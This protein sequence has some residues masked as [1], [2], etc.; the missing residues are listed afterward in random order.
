M[1]SPLKHRGVIV[2]MST[3]FTPGGDVDDDAAER[4][5]DRLAA[6]G[7]SVFVLGTTGE[8]SS[9]PTSQRERVVNSALRAAAKRV[10]VYAGIGDNSLSD[11][12]SAG[13]RYLKLGAAAVVAHM[14]SYYPIQPEEMRSYFERLHE[15]VHGPLMLYNI[16]QTT[17]MSLPL[18]VVEQL[19]SLPRVVGF[20]DS[21]N[22]PGRLEEVARRFGGRPRFSI[23]MG[24]ASQS[25]TAMRAG[26]DGVI[27]SS[28]NLVPE[29]WERFWNHASAGEWAQAEELQ[30][31]LD[32][33]GQVLQ[34]SRG[35]GGYLAALK[36]ALAAQ[37]ICDATVL[38]PL[39]PLSKQDREKVV[40][41]LKAIHVLGSC[42]AASPS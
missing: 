38:P 22:T 6:H 18:D 40:A 24:T 21:E 10:P 8:T 33:I 42:G 36:A 15:A 39:R 5:A 20:K 14:P 23:L 13:N 37:G 28:G 1:N 19:S 12:I 30:R 11:S 9:I 2:P 7:L 41:E 4:I 26:Y 27:P 17:R 34:G 3:P 32:A 25:L 31:K 35:L 29:L 16:P